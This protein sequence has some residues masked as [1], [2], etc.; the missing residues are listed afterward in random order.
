MKILVNFTCEQL[1]ECTGDAVGWIPAPACDHRLDLL[2]VGVDAQQ[3]LLTAEL[4]TSSA[5]E[6]DSGARY[7]TIS[8]VYVPISI[9]R[10][11][12]ILAACAIN[13]NDCPPTDLPKKNRSDPKYYS[14]REKP[15]VHFCAN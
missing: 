2:V 12:W 10:Y 4:V 6:T 9:S 5:P 15:K 7:E 8:A 11:A 3:S 13:I 14:H 1:R